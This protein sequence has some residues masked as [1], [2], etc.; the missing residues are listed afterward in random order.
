MFRIA[1]LGLLVSA[2][3][4]TAVDVPKP[5]GKAKEAGQIDPK[6]FKTI[7]ETADVIVIGKT[8]ALL[9]AELDSEPPTPVYTSAKLES[10]GLKFLKGREKLGSKATMSVIDAFDELAQPAESLMDKPVFAAF[11]WDGKAL[12]M[13]MLSELHPTDAAMIAEKYPEAK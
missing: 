1:L 8:F 11:K 4:L 3:T 6:Q 7:C 12:K 13:M 2:L 9:T 5:V 10:K